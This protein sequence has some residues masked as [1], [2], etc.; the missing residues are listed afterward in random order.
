MV[1]MIR[2]MDDP[3]KVYESIDVISQG[4]ALP[5]SEMI[6]GEDWVG[7]GALTQM[8]EEL[9]LSM[10]VVVTA[11]TENAQI[12]KDFAGYTFVIPEQIR[13]GMDAEGNVQGYRLLIATTDEKAAEALVRGDKV[14][15]QGYSALD[16]AFSNRPEFQQEIDVNQDGRHDRLILV[17]VRKA[18]H[19]SPITASFETKME[20]NPVYSADYDRAM[21]PEPEEPE[22][23]PDD[24]STW[25]R[26]DYD[27][28]RA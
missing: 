1:A 24:P 13:I 18:D 17:H 14:A 28:Y 12:V 20:E 7:L 21:Q 16:A 23:D 4:K 27:D 5:L 26:G 9:G 3:E 2:T 11:D 22:Y 19:V 15:M 25:D 8:R 6:A 10:P